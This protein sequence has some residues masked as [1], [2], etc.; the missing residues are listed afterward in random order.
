MRVNARRGFTLVELLVVVAMIGV[1]SALAI[2]G[3]RKYLQSSHSGEARAIL[4]GIRAGEENYRA[5]TLTYLGCS[6]CGGSPCPQGTGALTTRYPHDTPDKTKWNWINNA[7]A[8]A[9]CWRMLNVTADGPVHYVYSVVSGSPGQAMPGIPAPG[10]TPT[11]P[12]PT[13]EPWYVVQAVGDLDGDGTL[14]SFVASSLSGE[15]AVENESE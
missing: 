14:S 13:R 10:V 9:P 8:D 1:L 11:W 5:E 2:V 6:G 3:Y 7:H 4:Q 12:N 15:I